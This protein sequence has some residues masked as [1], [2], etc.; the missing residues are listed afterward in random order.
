MGLM[1]L[2]DLIPNKDE[3]VTVRT[4]LCAADLCLALTSL[5]TYAR[6]G[7]RKV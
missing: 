4:I 2:E 3:Q 7:L 5:L 6:T 1:G